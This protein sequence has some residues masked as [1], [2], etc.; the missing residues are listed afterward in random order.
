MLK[1]S[2]E[3]EFSMARSR[4]NEAT[5]ALVE[6]GISMS[7]EQGRDLAAAFLTEH[8]VQFGVVVRVLSDPLRRRQQ[9]ADRAG[10]LG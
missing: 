6:R 5:F 1:N 7:D 9:P 2:D 4:P 8:G 10:A 3:K